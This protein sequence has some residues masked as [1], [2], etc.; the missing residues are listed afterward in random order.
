M[1]KGRESFPLFS[2]INQAVISSMLRREI[3]YLIDRFFDNERLD[4][5]EKT[6]LDGFDK[7][8]FGDFLGSHYKEIWQM[9]E[10]LAA[11]KKRIRDFNVELNQ[12]IE[13]AIGG[14]NAKEEIGKF[15]KFI[16]SGINRITL[17]ALMLKEISLGKQ[18][19]DTDLPKNLE[20]DYE[21]LRE[22]FAL[23][24]IQIM[25][26]VR[27]SQTVMDKPEILKEL[28]KTAVMEALG[29]IGDIKTMI[30]EAAGG[31]EIGKTLD[32]IKAAMDEAAGKKE[33]DGNEKI[34]EEIGRIRK[35]LEKLDGDVG[36]LHARMDKIEKG[37]ESKKMPTRKMG[38]A[39]AN[40]EHLLDGKKFET[41]KEK[42]ERVKK[43]IE[44]IIQKGKSK[45]TLLTMG[46]YKLK[47]KFTTKNLVDIVVEKRIIGHSEEEKK[48]FLS[49]IQIV[50]SSLIDKADGEFI[51]KKE[52]ISRGKEGGV[53]NCYWFE[54]NKDWKPAENEKKLETDEKKKEL[55]K[56]WITRNTISGQRRNTLLAIA[57]Y[58][59]RTKFISEELYDIAV[60]KKIIDPEQITKHNF[61]SNIWLIFNS[62]SDKMNGEF[63]LKKERI[64]KNP[65]DGSRYWIDDNKNW[66]S[67]ENEGSPENSDAV[68]QWIEET[69][70]EHA[71]KAREV[72]LAMA[73]KEK[74]VGYKFRRGEIADLALEK[75]IVS[76][77]KIGR[78][79]DNVMDMYFSC[80]LKKQE[81]KFVLMKGRDE[82]GV[83]HSFEKNPEFKK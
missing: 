32:E 72:L 45:K 56:K 71:Y 59:L 57:E 21:V 51:L 60:E 30:N 52:K 18:F 34:I 40:D 6:T 74:C 53:E 46:E 49:T 15:M 9:R 54:K 65:R 76:P 42:I 50:F 44:T 75:G 36:G 66:E 2:D 11:G 26:T 23:A 1:E 5:G 55:V 69:I 81:G 70:S 68:K 82:F 63:I 14:F 37:Q 17:E 27:M 78:F 79:K 61:L 16:N 80:I 4:G 77:E 25:Q 35:I 43:W 33:N 12:F 19:K 73:E 3:V 83:Y 58:E 31:K 29:S 24:K 62:E 13:T 39:D 22:N 64:G 8:H 67:P 48:K 28:V 38:A 7:K 20:K 41:D 10:G 47:T